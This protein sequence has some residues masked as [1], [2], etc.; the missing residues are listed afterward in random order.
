MRVIIADDHEAVRKG[1]RTILAN[2]FPDLFC[3][4]AATGLEAVKLAMATQPDL[5]ILDINL[6]IMTGFAAAE[7]LRR[8]FPHI[9][10]LF[11]TM[12]AGPS[13]IS[14]AQKAGVQG[15]VAKDR[16][17]DALVDAVKTV[18]RGE[19]YFPT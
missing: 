14:E 7:E 15:F 8:L 11:F 5:V 18:L 2:G 6:P 10:V 4:E 13:F 16:A 19:T 9:P 12:H 17:A 1:V 3:D